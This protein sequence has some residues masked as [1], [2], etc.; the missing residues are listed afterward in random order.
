MWE[1]NEIPSSDELYHYGVLGMKWGVRRSPEQLARAR[2]YRQDKKTERTLK[3]HVSADT[4][5]LKTR[6]QLTT[7]TE[8]AYRQ[9]SEELRKE[10]ARPSLS[11][12]KK[13]A[14]VQEATNKVNETIPARDSAKAELL[15]ANR[16]YTSDEKALIDHVN[17]MIQDYGSE[18]VKNLKTKTINA[19]EYYTKEV[20][21]TG[22]TIVNMPIVGSWYAANY[23]SRREDQDRRANS[24]KRASS[25]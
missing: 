8:K 9:A 13:L 24:N 11:R 21:K 17:K 1:Y 15:R 10:M 20:V 25:M 7:D 5:N 3:R 22:V 6:G 14:R 2:A 19:G 18:S 4:K 12:K 23:T 16:I